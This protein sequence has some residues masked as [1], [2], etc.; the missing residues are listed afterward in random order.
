MDMNKV[1]KTDMRLIEK[2]IPYT[3]PAEI[4]LSFQYGDRLVRGIPADFHPRVERR[5][6]DTN[7]L[8]IVVTGQDEAGLEIRA[9]YLE[10]RDFPVTEWIVFLTNRGEKNT[11]ILSKIRV[12]DSCIAGSDP[13][14][15]HGN[16]DTV[17][18]DG[19]EFFTDRLDHE[20]SIAPQNGL[21]THWAFPYM[22]LMFAEYGINLAIGWPAQWLAEFAPCEQGVH[23]AV[24]QQYM[25][26]YMK[27][28]ETI[29]TPRMTLM[30]FTG[31]ESRARNM[32]RRWYFKHI[33]PRED[34]QPIP[35]KMCLHTWGIGGKQEFTAVT[36][37]NQVDAIDS[38]IR[39]GMKPDI[40]WIDA[41]WYPCDFTWTTTGNWWPN[42]DHFPN[43]LG[44]VGKKCE[45]EG[46]QF[47]L[48]FEP[49]RVHRDTAL[50]KEH[51]EWMLRVIDEKGGDG[52]D[53]LL[54]LADKDCQ[55]WLIELVDGYIKEYHIHIYRQDFNIAPLPYWM[56]NEEPDRVGSM[57]NFHTQG[58]LRFWDE[59]LVRNPGLWIDSCASGGRRN[60]LET[61]RR[62]VPLHYTDIGYG[63]HHIKQKQHRE[64][65]EW[66][67]YFRAHTMSW[68]QENGEYDDWNRAPRPVDEFAYQCAMAPAI[69][70]M[71]EYNDSD[72]RFAVANKMD[73]IW[74]E[75]A[76]LM[77]SGDYYPLTE[78]R[79]SV[80]DYYAMQ[81]EDPE[82]GKGFIQ[83]VRNIK[84]EPDSFTAK[85][86]ADPKATYAFWDRVS[87]ET[88]TMTGE[89]LQKGFTVSIPKRS[90]V[91]WFYQKKGNE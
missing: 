30:G 68:D 1:T 71:V 91:I 12:M 11:P 5:L 23:L 24:G 50:D 72:E 40:W 86:F 13:V 46:I 54:K 75:A 78:C 81:F 31:D 87:G 8:Q 85:P 35:P 62:A 45:K 59:L 55:D 60:D 21:G 77:L 10:Y 79:K 20:L 65:F 9:E 18:Q 84:A 89:E 7:M 48:W 2:L 17:N 33:L 53:R 43:G 61:M 26:M 25:N 73:P 27:P 88:M 16:G 80:E 22:R 83:V 66:I 14:L 58:Y 56:N 82:T 64:M 76:E 39:H 52:Y 74:R 41:G 90:G 57:E 67:P 63:M 34:G 29:R 37:E 69:T 4:P 28:G 3:S 49:E 36:E 15:I 38:Y 51:P 47:L 19:Y 44:P 42:P 6:V 70:S 32:W